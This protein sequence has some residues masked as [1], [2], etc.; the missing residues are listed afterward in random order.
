MG[1][2]FYGI[3]ILE[4]AAMGTGPLLTGT[5]LLFCGQNCTVEPFTSPATTPYTTYIYIIDQMLLAMFKGM[6][7]KKDLTMAFFY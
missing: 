3:L 1:L 7:N 4:N 2:G 5:F 6:E